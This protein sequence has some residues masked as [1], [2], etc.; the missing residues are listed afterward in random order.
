MQGKYNR[1]IRACVNIYVYNYIARSTSRILKQKDSYHIYYTI[2]R[3]P[4]TLDSPC[5]NFIL[6]P[7]EDVMYA[8]RQQHHSDIMRISYHI[9]TIPLHTQREKCANKEKLLLVHDV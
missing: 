2:Y 9:S 7:T 3:H 4:Y 1:Q 5:R 8:R 6:C